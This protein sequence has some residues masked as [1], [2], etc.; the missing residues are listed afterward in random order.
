MNKRSSDLT[1]TVFYLYNRDKAQRP[2][3]VIVDIKSCMFSLSN[4][5]VYEASLAKTLSVRN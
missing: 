2:L 3:L 4:E 1:I 5:I